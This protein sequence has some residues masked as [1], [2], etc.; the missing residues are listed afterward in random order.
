MKLS[1]E[2]KIRVDAVMGRENYHQALW[3]EQEHRRVKASATKENPRFNELVDYHVERTRRSYKMIINAYME[4]YRMD[5]ALI[6]E[7]DRHEIIMEIKT[8]VE[9][10]FHDITT[11]KGRPDFRH[12]LTNAKI[13]NMDTYLKSQFDRLVG[14]ALLE[15]DVARTDLIVERRKQPEAS[16]SSYE[17]HV[18]GD[19]IGGIQVGPHNTQNN[20][21][22]HSLNGKPQIR[23]SQLR[24]VVGVQRVSGVGDVEVTE[25]DI[26]EAEEI[27]GDPWVD[28][29]DATT[30]GD[31]VREFVLGL[32]TPE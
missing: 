32:F 21:G 8:L 30:F 16:R 11:R 25:L 4:G 5:G 10:R 23:W 27:G 17:L 20:T 12:P 29:C 24:P 2:A 14:E 19:V 7:E 3:G 22:I 31:V 18:H 6:D 9:R 26:K 1:P 13:P 15:L 28:L